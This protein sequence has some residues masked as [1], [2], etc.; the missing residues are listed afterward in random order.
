MA[1]STYAELQTAVGT[2]WPDRTDLTTRVTE[3]IAL[4]EAEL[5][6]DERCRRLENHGNFAV[7]AES[8]TLPTDF[9]TL[10]ALYHNGGTHFGPINIVGADML[11]TLR[12]Q[13]GGGAA[14]VP[15]YAAVVEG[16]LIF[17]PVPDSAYSLRMV[18]WQTI[19]ALSGGVN[20]LLT[21]HP[22]IYLYASLV[23]G[24]PYAKDVSLL[25]VW[26]QKLE[27]AIMALDL[28]NRNAQFGGGTLR[29]QIR[30]IG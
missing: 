24:A 20:W 26:E 27:A 10:E 7:D 12:G 15:R 8:E 21:S 18:Y 6:K 2:N 4:A 5:R 22:D 28:S 25:P 29:R 19:A 16:S 13:H 1:I 30:P 14:G 9:H 17:A 3:F 23:E 11:G